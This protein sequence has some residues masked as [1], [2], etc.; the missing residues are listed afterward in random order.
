MKHPN[1]VSIAALAILLATGCNK[2]STDVATQIA[3]LERKTNEAVERQQELEQQLADQKLAAERE[4]IE[5]ERM[6]IEEARA[7]LERQQGETAAAEAAKI[8]QREEALAT[9]EGKLE[10]L[11]ARIEEK[12]D[13]LDQRAQQLSERDRELAGSE[14]LDFKDEGAQQA[15]VGDYGMFYDALS[16]YGSWFET[17]DYG[18]VWQPVIVRDTTWRPYLR[19]RWVCSDRGWT[20]IS[21]EPYGWATYHYGRWARLRN[22]GW[23]WVPGSEWAP[24]WVS[25]R[26]SDR[27]V[28][29]A[30]LPPETL[31]YRNHHWDSSV[32]V[33]FGI[34]A[35]WFNFVEIRHF[36]G[37]VNLHCLPYSQNNI[38]IQQTVNVT[39]IHVQNHQVICGGPR[40]RDVCDRIG[41]PMPFYRLDMDRHD[42]PGRDSLAMQPKF[43]GDRLRVAAP[44]MDVAWNDGLKP[45]RV[46]GRLESM[47]VERPK[48]L[49]PEITERF[50]TN[51]EENRNK[52][53]LAITEL[54]GREKFN[55][56]RIE[57]LEGNRLRAVEDA[58]KIATA[59]EADKRSVR[60]KGKNGIDRKEPRPDPAFQQ[61]QRDQTLKQKQLEAEKNLRDQALKQQQL[62][63]AK[64]QRDQTLKQKQLEDAKNQR[65][66][67]LKKKQLEDAQN[68]RDQALKQQL[69]DAK[70]QR[71]Q[72]L[73]QQ[74]LEDA[75][76]QRDQTLKQNQLEAEKN[77][78]DQALKQKQ[79][80]DT[81]N[82]RDQTLKQKQLE[83]AKNQRDQALKQQQLEDA[84]NKRDQALKQ[85][86]LEDAKNQRDQ[87]LKQNKLEDAQ[88]KRDQALK[89]QQLEAA[90]N[91]RDQALKQK[92]LEDAQ[93]QRDQILKR[94]QLEAEQNQR[95]QTP[96]QKR[97]EEDQGRRDKALKQQQ[98]QDNQRR[99]Q[100][101]RQQKE[102]EKQQERKLADDEAKKRRNR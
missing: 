9:R 73:K 101:D 76:N 57:Q 63:D 13:E 66:Q 26:Y 94:Q 44:N 46:K 24:S 43:Q 42:R 85:Q 88:N 99:E 34:G 11:Q 2:P 54:G 17:P 39:N 30:P 77:Q 100:A 95:D 23:I 8:R 38:F 98:S 4:A 35:L 59:R 51:R 55:Q 58:R 49:S 86:Q 92:Q 93:I 60:D 41:R 25:W 71:D 89:Q 29:W 97:L 31:A 32:D 61:N 48:G 36:G 62:E 69:E 14:A 27:H 15:P 21:D 20:W 53:A 80:D 65:D 81:K 12:Q 64:N 75:K 70:N 3:D 74:Q 82:Q 18:Y 5:R 56:R 68:L 40:Y 84:Q 10:Q 96:K 78:R 37:P 47:T 16:S 79:L 52:A 1:L 83:D 72:T 7:D 28:G 91:Q 50:R 19:G 6:H 22:H 45:T 102:N 67:T 87:A 33:A 90:Q